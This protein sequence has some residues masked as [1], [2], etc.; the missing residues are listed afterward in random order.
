LAPVGYTALEVYVHMCI[1]YR[2]HLKQ[3][4]ELW[5][6]LSELPCSNHTK[7]YSLKPIILFSIRLLDKTIVSHCLWFF[8]YFCWLVFKWKYR[9][10]VWLSWSRAECDFIFLVIKTFFFPTSFLNY[11]HGWFL[12][13]L[14]VSNLVGNLVKQM[15]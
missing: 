12:Y 1:T 4:E 14:L 8:S 5:S 15:T 2:C 7:V 10:W 3:N 9:R 11:C 6:L 13:N